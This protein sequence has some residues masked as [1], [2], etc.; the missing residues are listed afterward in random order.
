MVGLL[1][2]VALRLK[3]GKQKKRAISDKRRKETVINE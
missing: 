1:L 2:D 3:N